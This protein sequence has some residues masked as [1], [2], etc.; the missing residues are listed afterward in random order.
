M[1]VPEETHHP[2]LVSVSPLIPLNV[3]GT[4][5]IGVTGVGENSRG[6]PGGCT[7]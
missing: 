1:E 6:V 4:L 2:S 3:L 5:V 7:I